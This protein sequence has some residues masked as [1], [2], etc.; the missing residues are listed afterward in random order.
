MSES[1]EEKDAEIVLM[2]FPDEQLLELCLRAHKQD[3]TLNQYINKILKDYINNLEEDDKQIKE[4]KKL[5]KDE[6]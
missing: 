5:L 6:I 2:D 1:E 3:V 4:I